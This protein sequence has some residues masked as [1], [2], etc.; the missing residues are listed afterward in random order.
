MPSHNLV[1]LPGILC[2][3]AERRLINNLLAYY[4]KLERPVV[5]ESDAIQLRFGLT[6]Q[7]IMNVVSIARQDLEQFGFNRAILLGEVGNGC[8]FATKRCRYLNITS[9]YTTTTYKL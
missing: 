3:P 7:Q 5:N 9:N 4:Q 8:C 2:G 6:L 1:L